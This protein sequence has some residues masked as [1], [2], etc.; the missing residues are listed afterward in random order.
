VLDTFDMVPFPNF[1]TIV[2]DIP[3]D[4]FKEILENAVACTQGADFGTNPDCGSGRFAQISGFE[5]TWSASG[6]GQ[7][8]DADGNVTTPGTRV[9]EATL[10]DGTV[11]IS[12]GVVTSG[13]DLNI[14]ITDF[15][16][17]GGDQYPFRGADFVTLGRTYQQALQGLITDDLSGAITAADY[18]EGGEGRITELP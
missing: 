3:R 14:A 15:L 7:I 1:V 9:Q 6:V 13:A 4:Q 17:N 16:A 10:A 8:V 11:I 18:P 5:F 12:G 2:P